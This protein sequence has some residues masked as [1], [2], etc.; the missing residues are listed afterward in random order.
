MYKIGLAKLDIQ[1]PCIT[2][3]NVGLKYSAHE[4]LL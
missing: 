2:N 1:K 4:A 3:N